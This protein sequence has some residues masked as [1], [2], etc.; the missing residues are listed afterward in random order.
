[1]RTR[2]QRLL[3]AY[4]NIGPSKNWRLAISF[5]AA[6]I[7]GA[8]VAVTGAPVWVMYPV[9]VVLIFVFLPWAMLTGIEVEQ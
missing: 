6:A 1:M 2:I 9:L 3:I 4:G 7:M 5:L 8:T